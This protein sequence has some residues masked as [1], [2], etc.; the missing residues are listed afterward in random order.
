MSG[1]NELA[2]FTREGM[3]DKKLFNI[4]LI[5]LFKISPVKAST[6]YLRYVP[7]NSNESGRLG[8]VELLALTRNGIH[9]ASYDVG[10]H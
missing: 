7:K 10:G 2:Y 1:T 9:K 8:T 6:S 5:Q 3:A 4:D